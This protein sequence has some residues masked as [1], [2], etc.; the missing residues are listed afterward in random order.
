MLRLHDHLAATHRRPAVQ[1][2]VAVPHAR[3]A[4]RRGAVQ[5]RALGQPAALHVPQGA[6][7]GP[8]ALPVRAPALHL[9]V[10]QGH[11]RV[12]V[13][14]VAR[15]RVHGQLAAADPQRGLRRRA[16]HAG[17]GGG[18]RVPG[19]LARRALPLHG[20]QAEPARAG[21]APVGRGPLPL[22]RL[23]G[24]VQHHHPG[25]HLTGRHLRRHPLPL[26]GLQ[27]HEADASRPVAHALQVPRLGDAAPPLVQPGPRA[28]VQL[29]PH[30][31]V[32]PPR[33]ARGPQPVV[34][35]A[36]HGADGPQRAA[37]VQHGR[38]GGGAAGRPAQAQRAAGRVP[39]AGG[40]GRAAAAAGRRPQRHRPRQLR[41]RPRP[42][43]GQD[44]RAR[45]IG[46]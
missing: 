19:H 25:R 39:L 13:A 12:R 35:H 23:R 26:R 38:A 3:R 31:R 10:Q 21:R 34:A 9:L 1:G 46:M 45:H 40:G 16:G 28:P 33:G 14:R 36:L 20:G 8:R 43:A 5:R 15:G 27:G 18:A 11:G 22:L 7:G 32:L 24:R 42:Q 17:P 29:Q 4:Q 2:S 6:Q 30:Q 37:L 41:P 44:G